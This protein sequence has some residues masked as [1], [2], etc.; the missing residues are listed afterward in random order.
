MPK[1]ALSDFPRSKFSTKIYTGFVEIFDGFRDGN[2]TSEAAK[3][4]LWGVGYRRCYC[5]GFKFKDG[6]QRAA[7]CARRNR[8][9]ATAYSSNA[10][11]SAAATKPWVGRTQAVGQRVIPLERINSAT[12]SGS[13]SGMFH[14]ASP[15]A[16]GASL[17]CWIRRLPFLCCDRQVAAL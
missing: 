15:R 4:P 6:R 17:D 2:L 8:S 11:R 1:S 16:I 10:V 12:A 5:A 13:F 14:P 9:R 3:R 7:A